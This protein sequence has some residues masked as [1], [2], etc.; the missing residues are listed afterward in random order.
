MAILLGMTGG[1]P[2]VP[3]P[4]GE[5]LYECRN[6][7]CAWVWRKV[8][9]TLAVA[10]ETAARAG[11]EAGGVSFLDSDITWVSARGCPYCLPFPFAIVVTH[12]GEE[13]K[14][15]DWERGPER[16]APH[17]RPRVR[18]AARG[19]DRCCVG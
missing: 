16:S 9:C 17:G 2:G 18:A 15:V 4:P 8:K 14:R 3:T 19:R 10:L 11:Y 1:N 12:Q 6:E 5:V 7:A 13:A